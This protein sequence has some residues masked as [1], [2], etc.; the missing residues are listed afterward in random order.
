MAVGVLVVEPW[1]ESV[2][3]WV[4]SVAGDGYFG[5]SGMG[6]ATSI[7]AAPISLFLGGCLV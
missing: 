7:I 4:E 6:K 5:A 3:A 2:G 1:L